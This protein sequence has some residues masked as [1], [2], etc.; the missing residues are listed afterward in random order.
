MKPA[1][2]KDTQA[3]TKA[4]EPDHARE[5]NDGGLVH[6][7]VDHAFVVRVNPEDFACERRQ[8]DGRWLPYTNLQDV[9]DNGRVV[10]ESEAETFFGQHV[11]VDGGGGD[12]ADVA[13]EGAGN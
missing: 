5:P 12:N 1:A 3:A 9:F 13:V 6:L 10:E 11:A 2:P 8:P 7:I 4:N